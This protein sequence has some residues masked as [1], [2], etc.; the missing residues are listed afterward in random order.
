MARHCFEAAAAI[1]TSSDLLLLIQE[2]EDPL[3][4]RKSYGAHSS[5]QNPSLSLLKG[6]AALS[7]EALVG[8]RLEMASGLPSV[9]SSHLT[10]FTRPV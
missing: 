6:N 4:R 9:V 10:Q 3:Q 2:V 8:D 7:L 1:Q 5:S